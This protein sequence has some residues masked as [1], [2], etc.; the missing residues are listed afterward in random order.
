MR[1]CQTQRTNFEGKVKTVSG[2]KTK[3]QGTQERVGP[4]ENLIKDME[5]R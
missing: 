5:E 3:L 4:S 2:I 1:V